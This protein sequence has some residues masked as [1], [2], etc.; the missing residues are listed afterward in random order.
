MFSIKEISN[1]DPGKGE[2]KNEKKKNS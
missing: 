1:N 2:P